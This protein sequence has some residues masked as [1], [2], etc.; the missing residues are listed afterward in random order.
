M[1]LYLLSTFVKVFAT[2]PLS[3]TPLYTP[4]HLS[5]I[6]EFHEK[7]SKTG[8]NKPLSACQF[9]GTKANG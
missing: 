4:V 6:I 7:S 3:P 2:I 5:N 1:N 8:E 9:S